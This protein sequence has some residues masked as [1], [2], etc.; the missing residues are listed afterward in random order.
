MNNADGSI[1]ISGGSSGIG[2][3]TAMA[4]ARRRK[5]P[6]LGL[7]A[8]DKARLDRAAETICAEIPT[9]EVRCFPLDVADSERVATTV[10]QAVTALGA[11]DRVVLAAGITLPG[12]FDANSL[13]VQREV[14]EINYF[15]SL[16]MVLALA[17]LMHA[18]SRIALVGSAA[19]LIGTYG[20]GGYAP[21]KF[22]LRGLAE[23]LRVE[24]AARGISVTL[25]LPPD[26][27]T[28]MLAA[29][30]PLRP[31]VTNRI[32]AGAPVLSASVVAN[33]LLRGMEAGRFLVL[34]G[35][36]VKLL[37]L[38]GPWVAPVARWQQRRL[39]RKLGE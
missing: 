18:G 8:R 27:D 22:A 38:F 7:F 28:P 23:V 31:A 25:C 20:Y 37:Y 2:L 34:P 5:K 4:Y 21:S 32:A 17:P 33:A 11:P 15:G 39:I 24:L 14:M 19:G 30:L 26:T 6:R 10:S 1:F 12:R 29:E 35:L 9:A 13:S 16:N 36:P 3:A